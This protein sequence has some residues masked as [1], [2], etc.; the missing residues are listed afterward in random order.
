M[1]VSDPAACPVG[2]VCVCPWS[3]G[4]VW[5]PHTGLAQQVVR[6][7]LQADLPEYSLQDQDPQSSQRTYELMGDRQVDPEPGSGEGGG[8]RFLC[9][10]AS[11]PQLW[12]PLRKPVGPS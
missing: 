1:D 6:V 12:G 11:V 9:T 8:R 4:R 2:C 3:S 10:P 7:C 5:G